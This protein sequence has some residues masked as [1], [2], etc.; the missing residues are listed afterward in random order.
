[1]KIVIIWS[2]FAE[3]FAA[4]ILFFDKFIGLKNNVSIIL[5]KSLSK[6]FYA[7]F[8]YPKTIATFVFEPLNLSKFIYKKV[9]AIK[10]MKIVT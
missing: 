7:M 8:F 6:D 1:M 4:P 5:N 10:V 3:F 9:Q 2:F